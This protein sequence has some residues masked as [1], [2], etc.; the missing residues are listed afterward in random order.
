MKKYNLVLDIQ[1]IYVIPLMMSFVVL[2]KVALLVL[3][4]CIRIEEKK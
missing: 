1:A 2:G 4:L 3:L